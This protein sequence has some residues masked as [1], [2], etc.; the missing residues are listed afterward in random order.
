[1]PGRSPPVIEGYEDDYFNNANTKVV[2]GLKDSPKVFTEDGVPTG[3]GYVQFWSGA[4]PYPVESGTSLG[5][6]LFTLVVGFLSGQRRFWSLLR[7]VGTCAASRLYVSARQTCQ[8]ESPGESSGSSSPFGRTRSGSKFQRHVTVVDDVWIRIA[9]D[10]LDAKNRE[11]AV[12]WQRRRWSALGKTLEVHPW[13]VDFR[14]R[15]FETAR[16]VVTK[17]VYKSKPRLIVTGFMEQ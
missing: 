10:Y 9:G 4:L 2:Y 15:N 6:I 3:V 16:K 5:L 13:A 1:M 11:S 14:E 12:R 7:G 17:K 8:P